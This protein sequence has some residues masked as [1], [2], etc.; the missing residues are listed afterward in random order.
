MDD[1]S[2]GSRYDGDDNLVWFYDDAYAAMAGNTTFTMPAN[3]QKAL[4]RIRGMLGDFHNDPTMPPQATGSVA[5]P[6]T[7]NGS[8]QPYETAIDLPFLLWSAGPD[9]RFGP[10]S[11]SGGPDLSK[12]DRGLL[13]RCDDVTNFRP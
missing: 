8:I 7:P 13:E 1:N 5:D 6:S 11:I 2:E 3:S 9:D 10:E 12:A 4:K